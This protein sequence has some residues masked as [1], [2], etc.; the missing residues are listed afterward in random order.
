[1]DGLRDVPFACEEEE[2]VVVGEAHVPTEGEGQKDSAAKRA[3][4]EHAKHLRSVN[5]QGVKVV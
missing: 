1:M 3:W 4:D 5:K 2:S